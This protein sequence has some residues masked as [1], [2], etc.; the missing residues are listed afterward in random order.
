MD[1]LKIVGLGM[2]S[3][4]LCV[5][6]KSYRPELSMVL[7]VTATVVIIFYV[8]PY[9]RQILSSLLR[10]SDYLGIEYEYI[11]PVFKVIGIAYITQIGGDLCR[12]AGETAI[13]SK[14]DFAGKIAIVS[15]AVPIA[16]KMISVV[17]GIIF[18]I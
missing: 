3:V 18:S 8:F 9:F 5:L 11:Y 12:D 4:M 10:M 14:I 6:I 13:A 15:L 17:N 16:Y 7:S 2:V 1:I